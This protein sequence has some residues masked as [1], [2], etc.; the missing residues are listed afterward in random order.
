LF[1]ALANFAAASGRQMLVVLD[2]KGD[3]SEWLSYQT[4]KLMICYSNSVSADAHI[5]KY[6]C[7]RKGTGQFYV[8]TRDRAITNMAHGFGANVIGTDVFISMLSDTNQESGDVLFRYRVKNRGFHRPF[9]E[10]L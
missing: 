2:G 8:V 1:H 3:D 6:L 5:E 7:Q 4:S 9:E 10:K